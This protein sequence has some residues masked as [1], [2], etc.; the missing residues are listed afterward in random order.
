MQI[1]AARPDDAAT[2]TKIAF[3]AKRHWGYPERW[4][5]S[6]R[7]LLTIPPEFIAEHEVY[8]A[9]L[10]GRSIGFYALG[11]KGDKLELLHL[12]VLPDM[13]G[14][15]VGRSMF[16][17]A[18]E[19]TKTSGCVELEI[20]SDP[21]AEGFYRKFGARR[22]GS[23]ISDVEEQRRELPLLVVEIDR[24]GEQSGRANELE[25]EHVAISI[26]HLRRAP[27]HGSS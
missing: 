21:N 14:R 19:R 17:H 25:R 26:G 23:S 22:V 20:E 24:T 16:L 27:R 7:D 15:G 9:V 3:A 5:E 1:V 10:D 12:W 11:R 2:L 13:M 4:I 8:A 18:I 6:W